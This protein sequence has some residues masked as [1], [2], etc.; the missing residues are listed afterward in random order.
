M[1]YRKVY[2]TVD[3]QTTK[4]MEKAKEPE[5]FCRLQLEY[6]IRDALFM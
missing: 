1:G 6:R 3:E 5:K 4:K 2:R